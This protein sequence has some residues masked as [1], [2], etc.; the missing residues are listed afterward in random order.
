MQKVN[1]IKESKLTPLKISASLSSSYSIHSIG[2]WPLS[3]QFLLFTVYSLITESSILTSRLF[4]TNLSSLVALKTPSSTFPS[5]YMK[6]QKVTTLEST[7]V[8]HHVISY[9][10]SM[11]AAGPNNLQSVKFVEHKLAV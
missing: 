6:P 9:T 10:I 4:L 8:H 3:N 1:L 7:S 2:F 5:L 11:S